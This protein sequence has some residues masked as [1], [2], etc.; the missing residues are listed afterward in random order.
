MALW[1]LHTDAAGYVRAL[2]PA[3]KDADFFRTMR[4]LPH[5]TLGDGDIAWP[6]GERWA[7]PHMTAADWEDLGVS[8]LGRSGA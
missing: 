1:M 8:P 7:S 5:V 4:A 3:G 2:T 6:G